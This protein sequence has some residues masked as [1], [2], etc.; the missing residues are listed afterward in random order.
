M[1]KAGGPLLTAMHRNS[2][3]WKKNQNQMSATEESKLRD[4]LWWIPYLD[5]ECNTLKLNKNFLSKS[6]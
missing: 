2:Q 1:I 5:A 4:F 3:T 6:A